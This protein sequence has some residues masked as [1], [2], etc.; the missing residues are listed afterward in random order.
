MRYRTKGTNDR[1]LIYEPEMAADLMFGRVNLDSWKIY[2]CG[3]EWYGNP[4]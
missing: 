2:G 4:F 1:Y 3:V